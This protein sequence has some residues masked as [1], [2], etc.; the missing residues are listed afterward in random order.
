VSNSYD[1][2]SLRRSQLAKRLGVSEATTFRLDKRGLGPPSYKV[3]KTRLWRES[4]LI[5]W[6]ESECRQDRGGR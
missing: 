6:L 5:A 3:G 4:D 1:Y 2:P